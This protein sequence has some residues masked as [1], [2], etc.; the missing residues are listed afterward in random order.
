MAL[1]ARGGVIMWRKLGLYLVYGAVAIGALAAL[2][3]WSE[4][5]AKRGP[6]SIAARVTSQGA[7]IGLEGLVAQRD[8]F[9]SRTEGSVDGRARLTRAGRVVFIDDRRDCESSP[10]APCWL[11][12]W[13]ASEM[14][15][16][17]WGGEAPAG[18]EHVCGYDAE[19][20]RK[21]GATA[22]AQVPGEEVFFVGFWDNSVTR[23]SRDGAGRVRSERFGPYPVGPFETIGA[24]SAD[25]VAFVSKNG[26]VVLPTIGSDRFMVLRAA[27][28][29]DALCRDVTATPDRGREAL[30]VDC[31]GELQLYRR[32]D[33]RY[34]AYFLDFRVRLSRAGEGS[35]YMRSALGGDVVMIGDQHVYLWRERRVI[36][37]PHLTNGMTWVDIARIRG[38]TVAVTLN[39]P[40]HVS[41]RQFFIELH[42]IGGERTQELARINLPSEHR[43]DLSFGTLRVVGRD[44]QIMVGNPAWYRVYT[45]RDPGAPLT[46]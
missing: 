33:A 26:A 3:A 21:C 29:D 27:T 36:G 25:S 22:F 18:W 42:D 41:P 2:S 19:G 31:A 7:A 40:F 24:A 37:L 16:L 46:D 44:V 12:R 23:L 28:A 38:R 14:A 43:A 13:P 30:L 10:T 34:G 45:L 4:H 5:D 1:C 20:A 15:W 11:R 32:D 17:E 35:F 9:V 8:R 39:A 6:D